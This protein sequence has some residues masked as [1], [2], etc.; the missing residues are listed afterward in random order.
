MSASC[1]SSATTPSATDCRSRPSHSMNI[2]HDLY[3]NDSLDFSMITAYIMYQAVGRIDRTPQKIAALKK[4]RR[5]RCIL[6]D[7]PPYGEPISVLAEP[8]RQGAGTSS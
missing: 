8:A 2:I 6:M 3:D 7:I 5:S 4:S 1:A